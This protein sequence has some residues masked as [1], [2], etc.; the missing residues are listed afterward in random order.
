VTLDTHSIALAN[1]GSWMAR[2]SAGASF[3]TDTMIL[4]NG[5]VLAREGGAS[6]LAG[7]AYRDLG[8]TRLDLDDLGGHLFVAS[9]TGDTSS[10]EVLVRNGAVFVQE[11]Q[12]FPSIAPHALARTGAAPVVLANSGD[13]FWYGQTSNPD[14]TRNQ[15]YFRNR[16]VLVQE[17]VTGVDGVTVASVRESAGAF[18]ASDSGRFWIG[19][20]VLT[21]GAETVLLADFGAV[22][23]LPACVPNP[24]SLRKLSGDAVVGA[25]LTLEMTGGQAPGVLPL[26]LVSVA[27]AAPGSGCGR[28]TSAGEVLIDVTGSSLV[29][30]AFGAPWAGGP[31]SFASTLPTDPSLIDLVV[32][33]QGSFWDLNGVAPAQPRQHLTDGLVL[34]I[35]AP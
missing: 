24:A 30:R 7:R 11:G 6:P 19:E 9:L 18:H 34:E 28:T 26:L 5:E 14:T 22:V 32:Y 3:S 23:P 27:Q 10:N 17:G 2:I 31:V 35:G 20:V 12:S 25:T 33:A 4:R 15:V 16:E 29:H 1:D 21:G 13:V 8:T